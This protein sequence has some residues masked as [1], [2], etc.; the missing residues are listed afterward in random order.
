M[1]PEV[2]PKGICEL[3]QSWVFSLVIRGLPQDRAD[4]V[5]HLVDVGL[6]AG[7]QVPGVDVEVPGTGTPRGSGCA[8]RNGYRGDLPLILLKEHPACQY[9]GSAGPM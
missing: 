6:L 1:V 5:D 3:V 4:P 2:C 7:P 8:S 9:G